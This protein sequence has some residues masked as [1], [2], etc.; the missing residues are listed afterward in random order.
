MDG[1]VIE[2]AAVAG[3]KVNETPDEISEIQPTELTKA[4][5]KRNVPV[6]SFPLTIKLL[7][8]VGRIVF[9]RRQ[10]YEFPLPLAVSVCVEA[11]QSVFVPL[12]AVTIGVEGLGDIFRATGAES[13]ETQPDEFCEETV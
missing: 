11:P 6:A 3:D 10:I 9:P 5:V 1:V 8:V 7:L 12:S 13:S 4:A 2:G